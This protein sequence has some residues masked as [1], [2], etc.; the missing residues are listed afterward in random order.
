MIP[1]HFYYQLAVLGL[2]WLCVLL[3]LA[4]SRSGATPQTKPA[5]PLTPRRTRSDEPTP[6]AGLTD[7]VWTTEELLAYRVPVEFLDQLRTIEHLFPGWDR[8]HHSN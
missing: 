6:F 2:L 5:M 7:H 8:V 4:G 3:H 1:H